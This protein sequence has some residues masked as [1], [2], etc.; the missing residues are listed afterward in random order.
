MKSFGI[1]MSEPSDRTHHEVE[2][3][4]VDN[5]RKRPAKLK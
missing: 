1:K 3:E 5:S 2:M 4:N